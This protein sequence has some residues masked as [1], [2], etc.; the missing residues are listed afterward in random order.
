MTACVTT[1]GKR[2]T[3][4][5][6]LVLCRQYAGN[7]SG[8]L[9][10]AL[11]HNDVLYSFKHSHVC[12][13]KGLSNINYRVLLASSSFDSIFDICQLAFT[14]QFVINQFSVDKKLI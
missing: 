4:I 14:C 9:C 13:M 12:C 7:N 8:S 3:S 11:F 1:E 2:F 6:L 5:S 10:V